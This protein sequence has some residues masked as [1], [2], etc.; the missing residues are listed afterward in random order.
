MMINAEDLKLDHNNLGITFTG[1]SKPGQPLQCE[2]KD[3]N[4]VTLQKGEI[5]IEV[6]QIKEQSDSSY[7]G[8]IIC[9]EP[10]ESLRK[11]GV[12]EGLEITF[13][14]EH[15]FACGHG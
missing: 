15:I 3:G 8:K 13:L 14:K 4:S 10:Y 6:V 5:D 9:I 11:E 12:M 7:H 1:T 2:V